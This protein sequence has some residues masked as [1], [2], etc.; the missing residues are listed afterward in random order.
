MTSTPTPEVASVFASGQINIT[1]HRGYRWN[2]QPDIT[3]HEL[4]LCLPVVVSGCTPYGHIDHMFLG[5][6]D[7]ARRHFK[8]FG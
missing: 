7:Q 1:A 4:A 5:L 2:P 8:E 6:P 3:A